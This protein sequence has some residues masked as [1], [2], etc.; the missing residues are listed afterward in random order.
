MTV[1]Q[2][3]SSWRQLRCLKPLLANGQGEKEF[4]IIGLAGNMIVK[5]SRYGISADDV[6]KRTIF[7]NHRGDACRL[8]RIADPIV[9]HINRETAFWPLHDGWRQ[10]LPTNSA[11]QPFSASFADFEAGI[12]ALHVFDDFTVEVG[13]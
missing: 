7:R 4:V 12:E 5:Q 9:D 11:V 6:P 1:C 2:S 8:L 3:R 13:N 10:H